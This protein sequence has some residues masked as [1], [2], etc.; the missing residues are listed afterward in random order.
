MSFVR[1]CGTSGCR[2]EDEARCLPDGHRR[3]GSASPGLVC[4]PMVIRIPRVFHAVDWWNGRLVPYSR[5]GRAEGDDRDRVATPQVGWGRAEPRGRRADQRPYASD[6]PTLHGGASVTRG[7]ETHRELHGSGSGRRAGSAWRATARRT[8]AMGCCGCSG[9]WC[10]RDRAP[11]SGVGR[12]LARDPSG[13]FVAFAS[14]PIPGASVAR[15]HRGAAHPDDGGA[16]MRTRSNDEFLQ[17]RRCEEVLD[18]EP[19]AN[20]SLFY[21]IADGCLEHMPIRFDP[22]GPVVIAQE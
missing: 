1:L 13:R 22:V 12:A 19:L 16:V 8:D 18:A 21:R 5:F 20:E 11:D 3:G 14:V 4:C 9:R 17:R 6:R 10:A 2:S 15:Q 7:F